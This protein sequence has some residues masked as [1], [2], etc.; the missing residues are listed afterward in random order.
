MAAGCCCG[1]LPRAELLEGTKHTGIPAG[2]SAEENLEEGGWAPP[3]AKQRVR[4]LGQVQ[5]V[6]HT[7]QQPYSS[8]Q[9]SQDWLGVLHS[10]LTYIKLPT[11]LLM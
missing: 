5:S 7:V 4:G 10:R 11:C 8:S 2:T 9:P 3:E 1:M 6:S